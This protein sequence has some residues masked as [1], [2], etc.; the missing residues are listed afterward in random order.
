[1][2][3]SFRNCQAARDAVAQVSNL[4]Y[5]RFSICEPFVIMAHP[6]KWNAWPSATRRYGR[7]QFCA[8]PAEHGQPCPRESQRAIETRGQSCPRSCP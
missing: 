1:M 5:R 2:N 3:V 4:L 7:I 6:D 8:T